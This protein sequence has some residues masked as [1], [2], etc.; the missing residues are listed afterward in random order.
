MLAVSN[1][2]V[3]Y[4]AGTICA[5]AAAADAITSEGFQGWDAS[6]ETALDA[7]SVTMCSH[8]TEDILV[9]AASATNAWSAVTGALCPLGF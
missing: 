5:L 4:A 9:A 1:H 3:F 6:I 7:V 8:M 2:R